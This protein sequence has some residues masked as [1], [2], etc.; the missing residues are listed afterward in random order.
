MTP[1]VPPTLGVMDATP[2]GPDPDRDR[3]QDGDQDRAELEA[4][5]HELAAI[6]REL[7]RVELDTAEPGAPAP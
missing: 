5:E 7:E 6:E 2:M 3:D 1:R 4:A